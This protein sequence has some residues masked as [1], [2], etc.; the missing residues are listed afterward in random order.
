MNQSLV[1]DQHEFEPGH[2]LA[3]ESRRKKVAY[4]LCLSDQMLKAARDDDWVTVEFLDEERRQLLTDDI[5]ETEGADASLLVDAISALITV[6]QEI[7]ALAEQ[8]QHSIQHQHNQHQSLRQASHNYATVA[9][10]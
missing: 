2:V 3:S 5:F 9:G 8:V 4:A 10:I 1:Q 7:S 6:N